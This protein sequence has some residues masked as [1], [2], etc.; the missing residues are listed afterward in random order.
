MNEINLQDETLNINATASYALSM[1]AGLDGFSYC[2]L[3]SSRNKYIAIRHIPF[4]FEE[5]NSEAF[6]EKIISI[7]DADEYLCCK[8]KSVRFVFNTTKYTLV[9]EP[10]FDKEQMKLFLSFNHELNDTEALHSNNIHNADAHIIFSLP[11]P[12]VEAVYMRFPNSKLYHSSIPFIESN[13]IRFKFKGNK[14]KVLAH[15]NSMYFDLIVINSSGMQLYNSF[16]YKNADDLVYY[17]M[18]IYDQLKLNPE[19]A[20]ILLSGILTKNSEAHLKLKRFIR[21]I[22]FDKHNDQFQYSYIFND[23]PSGMFT[24]LVNLYKCE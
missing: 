20:D 4:F 9:P 16:S 2:I 19:E 1:Q 17:I 23:V 14:S 3:D 6:S 11:Y 7:I 18:Y 10:L 15:A 8:Y 21:N 22:I 24:N 12:L 5:F 13:L